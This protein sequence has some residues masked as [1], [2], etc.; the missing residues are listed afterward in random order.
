MPVLNAFQYKQCLCILALT[1]Y[2]E[3]FID[4]ICIMHRPEEKKIEVKLMVAKKISVN[5]KTENICHY[6]LSTGF[7]LYLNLLTTERPKRLK[8]SLGDRAK[9]FVDARMLKTL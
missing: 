9:L 7:L 3:Q 4:Q 1:K 5:V 8:N 6:D 2:N